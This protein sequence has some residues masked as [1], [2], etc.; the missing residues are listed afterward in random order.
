MRFVVY[1]NQRE[2][3]IWDLEDKCRVE[4][5]IYEYLEEKGYEI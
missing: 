3:V 2:T 1:W 4:K 5:P